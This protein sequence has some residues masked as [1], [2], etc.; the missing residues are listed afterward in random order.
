MNA[1]PGPR[2]VLVM[3]NCQTHHSDDLRE[4]CANAGVRLIY[5]PPYSCDYNPI[6]LSFSGLKAW[7]R[8]NQ[9]LARAFG[10][11]FVE[12]LHLA[13]QYCGVEQHARGYFRR[14]G[15]EVSEDAVDIDYSEL[16]DH[17]AY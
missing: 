2:S 16:V 11:E 1:Y 17:V 5:I 9:R 8:R 12:F 15:I 4:M 3:D 13:V 6:E 7:M 10:D 14:A